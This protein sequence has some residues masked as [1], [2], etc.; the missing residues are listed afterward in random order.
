MFPIKKILSK[1]KTV[2]FR[3][4]CYEERMGRF[5]S[6]QAKWKRLRIKILRCRAWDKIAFTESLR[7]GLEARDTGGAFGRKRM[8]RDAH[9]T[10]EFHVL[11]DKYY[12]VEQK[13]AKCAT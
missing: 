4:F 13:E 5:F 6:K 8:G 12:D 1:T 10:E 3:E 11:I 7:H 9:A 2:C